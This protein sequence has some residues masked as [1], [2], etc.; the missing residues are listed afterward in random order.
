MAGLERL[1]QVFRILIWEK[2]KHHG[3]SPIQIQLLIFIKHHSPELATVS[4]LAQEFNLT[5]PTISDAIKVLEEKKIIRKTSNT[6]DTRS[7]FIQLTPLGHTI[8]KEAETF[9]GPISKVLSSNSKSKA[10][11]WESIYELIL[12]LNKSQV[13]TV[14]R[15]CH[16]CRHFTT[17]GKQPFCSLLS[18]SLRVQDI[19]IDCPEYD[20]NPE[21]SMQPK[22]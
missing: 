13:I 16:S 10:V 4:Y 6:A 12:E 7:S 1:A 5:K 19:R 14:Q 17:K 21:H 18:Q 22:P 9:T 20:L 2:A 8:V 11:L 15:T 3:L